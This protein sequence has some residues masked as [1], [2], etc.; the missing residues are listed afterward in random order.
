MVEVTGTIV[1]VIG[2]LHA[3]SAVRLK[4]RPATKSPIRNLLLRNPIKQKTNAAAE[5]GIRGRVPGWAATFVLATMVR[6]AVAGAPVGVIDEEE[7][8][9]DKLA[10]SPTHPKDTA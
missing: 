6:V 8:A 3:L 7:K 2:P 5:A 10:G 1:L 9:H 4:A